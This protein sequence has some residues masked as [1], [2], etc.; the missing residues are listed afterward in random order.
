MEYL[1]RGCSYSQVRSE[2]SP[3]GRGGLPAREGRLKVVSITPQGRSPVSTLTPATSG[4][5]VHSTSVAA[6][7][8]ERERE[9]VCQ[10][11]RAECVV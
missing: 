11:L 10:G 6:G 1:A 3:F 2:G 5:P 4:S 9:R 8:G 7:Q